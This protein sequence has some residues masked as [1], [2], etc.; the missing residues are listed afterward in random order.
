MEDENRN[1]YE[2]RIKTHDS[3]LVIGMHG[4]NLQSIKHLLARMVER[5]TKKDVILHFEVNDYVQSRDARFFEF[6]ERKI[7][8]AMRS[9][10]PVAMNELSSYER[11]KVHGYIAD[12]KTEG[13]KSYSL[14]EGKARALYLEYAKAPKLDLEEDGVGI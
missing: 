10:K 8:T 14:G 4:Q 9:G 1:I 3:K 12:K 5:K 11:K 7:E 6:I 13:L 2:L